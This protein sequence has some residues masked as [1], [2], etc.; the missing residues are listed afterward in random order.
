MAAGMGKRFGGDGKKQIAQLGPEGE[1]LMEYSIYDA[2]LAGFDQFIIVI[3]PAMRES[4]PQLMSSRLS[5]YNVC[6]AV[7]SYDCLPEW[8]LPPAGRE[9]PYGTVSA[10]LAAKAFLNKPF[11]V[12][13][14]DDFYGRAAFAD[15][16]AAMDRLA[17]EHQACTLTYRLASTL[18]VTGGVTRGICKVDENGV[19]LGIDETKGIMS[20]EGGTAYVLTENGEKRQL[21]PDAPTSMNIFGFK[22]WLAER[23]AQSFEKFLRSIPA[24]AEMTAEYCV[25]V[26]LDELVSAGELEIEAIPTA[27]QWFG[28]TYHEEI[29]SVRARLKAVTADYDM[30]RS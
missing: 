11:A 25:P 2:A 6:Y 19:L 15:L 13:N 24:E 5:R 26:M 4:F 30:S 8:F 3:S 20:G 9:K 27:A 12:I 14:A 22:P 28:I 21:A 7:Q 18:S 1:L 23:A 16:A 10:V 29:D 17:A